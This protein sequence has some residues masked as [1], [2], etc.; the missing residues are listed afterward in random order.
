MLLKAIFN[1]KKVLSIIHWRLLLPSRNESIRLHKKILRQTCLQPNVV[2][3]PLLFIWSSGLWYGFYAWKISFK[4]AIKTHKK[5]SHEIS[6]LN[7]IIQTLYMALAYNCDPSVT[8]R[9]QFYKKLQ[10]RYIFEYTYNFQSSAI[11][12][13]CN[14]P[15]K[16][17]KA[18]IDFLANKKVFSDVISNMPGVVPLL[19][20]VLNKDTVYIEK[21]LFQRK[22]LFIK[23]NRGS[24]SQHAYQLTYSKPKDSYSLRS[25]S[26][27]GEEVVGKVTI[28]S[29]L[30]AI[31]AMQ[32]LLVQPLLRDHPDVKQVV[33]AQDLTTFR[34]VTVKPLNAAATVIHNQMEVADLSLRKEGR[35]YYCIYKINLA[36][37]ELTAMHDP[38][39]PDDLLVTP[40]LSPMIIT[41]LKLLHQRCIEIHN[42]LLDLYSV[43]FDVCICKEGPVIIEA[44]SG[45]GVGA[46]GGKFKLL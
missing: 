28:A 35:Q 5:L 41:Y 33:N 18:A 4:A 43:A 29:T 14:K 17:S 11:H 23:P 42:S 27:S 31:Y 24:R 13:L 30:R 34:I 7:L 16:Q 39:L 1:R 3:G 32:S 40:R 26:G 46:L 36:N 9:F 6:C 15:Y 2:L 45:W 44:N 10:R 20:D 37:F 22:D 25:L 12:A 19:S 21:I 8:Y 38:N